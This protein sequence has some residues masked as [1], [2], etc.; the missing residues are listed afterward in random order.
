M[1]VK[2]IK[3]WWADD[4]EWV[5]TFERETRLLARVSDPGIVQIYDVGH[6]ARGPVLRLG[7]RRRREP[8]RPP[9]PG[10]AARVGGLRGRRPAVPGAGR[11]P[12]PAHRAPR[13]QARQHHALRGGPS[14]GRRLRGCPPGR[15]EHRRD[16]SVDRRHAALHGP[17][18][19]PGPSHDA[20]HRRLQRRRGPLRD[21]LRRPAVHRH[22]SRGTGAAAP[23]GAAAAAVAPAAGR[24]GRESW[25]ARWPRTPRGATRTAPRWREA[26]LRAAPDTLRRSVR[27]AGALVGAA[28]GPRAPTAPRPGWAGRWRSPPEPASIAPNRAAASP[29]RAARAR[30]SRHA[31]RPAILATAQRQSRRGAAGPSRLWASSSPCSWRWWQRPWSSATRPTRASHRWCTARRSGPFRRCAAAHLRATTHKR[32]RLG[33][34]GHGHRRGAAGQHPGGP[35]HHGAPHDQPRTRPGAGA[36]R[37][38]PEPHRRRAD[39]CTTWGSAPRSARSPLPARRRAWSWARRPRAA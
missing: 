36:Q 7:A 17:R 20:R 15:G 16:R 25:S 10:P 4:P 2:V 6:A 34:G 37:R 12:R 39:R 13:R 9:A 30:P 27:P 32:L 33:R 5:A 18:A 3:P 14:E 8:R 21:A 31:A 38:S 22:L 26:L 23:P 19:G 24:A 1:A 11:R 28:A 35:R 29:P